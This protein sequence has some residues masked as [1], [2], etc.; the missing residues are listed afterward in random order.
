MRKAKALRIA[1]R[2]VPGVPIVYVKR[3]VMILEPM[4]NPSDN[5]REGLEKGKLRAGLDG[6]AALGKRKRGDGEEGKKKGGVKKAKG[7]NPLSMKKPKKR[8]DESSEGKSKQAD[9]K[10]S[11]AAESGGAE[12]AEKQE[13]G[14][15]A[16]KPKRK[17]RHHKSAKNDGGD[18]D[19]AW[20]N[21]TAAAESED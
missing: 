2:A 1:A 8:A 19:G 7:P 18:G 12:A 17:R 16:P 13:D 5:V 11:D 4:S 14:D 15:S 3:S 10:K 9:K 21:E 6:D 20:Q